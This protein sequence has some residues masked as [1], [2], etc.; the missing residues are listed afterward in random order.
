MRIDSPHIVILADGVGQKQALLDM[1]KIVFG[2]SGHTRLLESPS[3]KARPG[4]IP[5]GMGFTVVGE[6]R[7]L[8]ARPGFFSNVQSRFLE[9]RS[10][11]V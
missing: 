4:Y 6:T 11:F 8:D 1:A 10:G 7:L 2:A 5:E 9:A 3:V